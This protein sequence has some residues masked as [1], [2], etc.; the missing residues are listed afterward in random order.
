MAFPIKIAL[1]TAAAFFAMAAHA[2]EVPTLN[3]RPTCTPIGAT[4]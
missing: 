1:A 4:I 3:V 2:S